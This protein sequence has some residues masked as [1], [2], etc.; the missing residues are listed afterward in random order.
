M[1]PSIYE[2]SITLDKDIILQSIDPNDPLY[3][4]G[5]II[6]GDPNLPVLTLSN[7]STACEITGLTIRAGSIG[8]AGSAMDA[9]IRNCRIMDNATHGIELSRESNPHLLNCLITSNGQTGIT[10]LRSPGRTSPLCAPIIENCIIVQNDSENTVGGE[11][12]II[13]SIIQ[14]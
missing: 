11:P 6:Q 2:E 12:V 9:T 10:M 3:I 13:D 5:T 14:D 4:G 7:N 1:E 8:I